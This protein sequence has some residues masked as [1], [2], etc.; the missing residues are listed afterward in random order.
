MTGEEL[1][2]VEGAKEARMDPKLIRVLS[3]AR[4]VSA[5]LQE[6]SEISEPGYQVPAID[7]KDALIV[8]DTV[9]GGK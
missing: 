6:A 4:R 1:R 3:Q 2:C 7:L 9:T 5:W 8:F